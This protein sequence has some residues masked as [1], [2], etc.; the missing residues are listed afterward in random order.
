MYREDEKIKL[1]SAFT[2]SSNTI[3][4]VPTITRG[5]LI[6]RKTQLL[7][8]LKK[9]DLTQDISAKIDADKKLEEKISD[10]V[11]RT[12]NKFKVGGRVITAL[13]REKP[14]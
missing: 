4:Q 7:L 6:D 8:A 14:D 12:M 3:R 9:N 10:D 1:G 5:R 2:L 11:G 13:E